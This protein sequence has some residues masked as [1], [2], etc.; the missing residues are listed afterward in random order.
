M[1]IIESRWVQ[2]W[3]C[4]DEGTITSF[5]AGGTIPSVK[6]RTQHEHNCKLPPWLLLQLKKGLD[7]ETGGQVNSREA[8]QGG[9]T[10]VI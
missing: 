2:G 6:L 9:M 5:M 7:P 8:L 3:T 4:E 10:A 1:I